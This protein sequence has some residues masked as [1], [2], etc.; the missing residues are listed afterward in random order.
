MKLENF[1]SPVN[2]FNCLR[3]FL[4]SAIHTPVPLWRL[5]DR[6]K[7]KCSSVL[8][9]YASANGKHTLLGPTKEGGNKLGI[10]FTDKMSLM[11]F[12]PQ[13]VIGI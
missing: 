13:S 3:L 4:T 9:C 10:A 7:K 5:K 8:E 1:I 12:K 2:V 6:N 11:V